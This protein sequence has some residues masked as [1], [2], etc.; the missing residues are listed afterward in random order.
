MARVVQA[1][2]K[3]PHRTKVVFKSKFP[4]NTLAV[5]ETIKERN[6][7]LP[8]DV[9]HTGYIDRDS[10]LWLWVIHPEDGLI[11]HS[12]GQGNPI[13]LVC[14]EGLKDIIVI[15]YVGDKK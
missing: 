12:T 7:I 6:K 10:G 14:A 5:A 15:K 1:I 8:E 11:S 13:R 4:F 9:W 2:G 3:L